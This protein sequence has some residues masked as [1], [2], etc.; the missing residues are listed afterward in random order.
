VKTK[1]KGGDTRLVKDNPK[2]PSEGK[3]DIQEETTD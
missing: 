1:E 2:E 3:K